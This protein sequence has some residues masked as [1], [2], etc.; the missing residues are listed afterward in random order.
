MQLMDIMTQDPETIRPDATLLEA[1]RKMK[2]LDVGLIPVC[3]GNRLKGMLTDRDITVR[4][5]AEGREPGTTKVDE[6][7]TEDVVYCFEDQTEQE[8]ADKMEQHK[9]RRLIV[10]DRDKQLTGI[11]SLGDVATKGSRDSAHAE[12]LEEVSTPSKPKR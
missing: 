4:A 3:D 2:E 5:T 12:A 8:A 10:L 1:A 11:V 7:M 9:I 6:V